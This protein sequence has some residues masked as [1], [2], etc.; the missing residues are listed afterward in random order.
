MHAHVTPERYKK[1]IRERGEWHG[2][3]AVAGELGLGGFDKM[4]DQRLAE[5]DS[6]GVDMQLVTPTVGFYQYGN[7]LDVTRRIALE[8]NDEIAE[9]VAAHPARFSGLAT[10]P[11]QD[12][13]SAIAEMERAMTHLGLQGVII[14]DHVAGRTYDEPDFLPFFTAA[15]ELGAIVFFHQGGDTVVS[16]RI[17]RYKLG[18][19]VGNLTERAL[20]FATL[21]FGGVLDR[22]PELKPYLAH[23]GGFTSFGVA[24]MDKVAG[25]LEPDSGEGFIPPFGQSDGFAQAMPPSDYLCAVPLRLLHIQRARPAL[26]HRRGRH[27]PGRSGHRLSSPHGPARRG[28]LGKR[29]PRAECRREGGNPQREP[30]QDPG[31]GV[32]ERE[33]PLPPPAVLPERFAGALGWGIIGIGNIVR[34][35]MAPAMVVE[36]ACDLVA[37]V[38]RDQGRADDFAREFGARFAYTDYDEMLANPEVD[39]VFIATPNLFHADQVVAAA[40]AGKHVLCDKPL[41]NNVADARRA[42]DACESAGVSLGV[43]FHNRHLPWVRDVSRL[44]AEGTIGDVRVVQLQVASG[45]RHYDNW[46]ADPVMA[47]LGSVHN[48]GVHGLDF[49]RVLLH[50]EPVEVM[51]MF[52]QAARLG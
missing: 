20:V 44:I 40:G 49:L 51:A 39:A 12:P 7:E 31:L 19:A 3:D 50:S 28:Q 36:P 48:V 14:S 5:M 47:G 8:C 32:T 25:A 33:A 17:S 42:L 1:A 37:A 6:L 9:M 11:M 41:G 18:N 2:L 29:P 13:P 15:E 21:V 35:T 4:L 38:S 46:R 34:S 23:G 52:D 26:P 27:R 10:L 30:G 24:R 43:N 22:C 45:P 16:H